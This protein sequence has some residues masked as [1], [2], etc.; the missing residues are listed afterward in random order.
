MNSKYT[1]KFSF[2]GV[3]SA[4]V[5][6]LT[7]CTSLSNPSN[8]WRIEFS[9]SAKSD[10]EIVFRIAPEYQEYFEVNVKVFKGTGENH[11][12]HRVKDAFLEQLPP[13]Q[14]SVE[15]DDGE[16]VLLK[17]KG[18]GDFRLNLVSN[19]VKSVRINLDRE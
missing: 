1:S 16:D 3:I 11:V 5:I 17:E 18:A 12:A 15:V 8:K 13:N 9:E 7:S 10:G 6:L 2:I 4:L 19:T 14:Y